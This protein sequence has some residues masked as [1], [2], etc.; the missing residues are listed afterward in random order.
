[1]GLSKTDWLDLEKATRRYEIWSVTSETVELDET[2]GGQK[3]KVTKQALRSIGCAGLRVRLSEV[4]KRLEGHVWPE[5]GLISL[6]VFA[7]TL[8]LDQ[9][10]EINADGLVVVARTIEVMELQGKPLIVR[11]SSAG[12]ARVMEVLAGR[13]VGGELKLQFERKEAGQVTPLG[14]YVVV[15]AADAYSVNFASLV[16]NAEGKETLKTGSDSD[17]NTLADLAETPFALG[18]FHAGIEAAKQLAKSEEQKKVQLAA[19]MLRW[20]EGCARASY[21]GEEKN[22]VVVSE[23]AD[24]A[25]ALLVSLRTAGGACFV[26]VLSPDV[27]REQVEQY[28]HA[29]ELYESDVLS[30]ETTESVGQVLEKVSRGL[31]HSAETEILPLKTELGMVIENLKVLEES[32]GSLS[33]DYL[34]QSKLCDASYRALEKAA[35]NAKQWKLIEAGIKL[36]FEGVSLAINMARYKKSLV[37]QL[38]PQLSKMPQKA[39]N[40]IDGWQTKDEVIKSIRG[41]KLFDSLKSTVLSSFSFGAAFADAV[42]GLGV[43]NKLIR[44]AE[45]LLLSQQALVSNMERAARAWAG[46]LW[47]DLDVPTLPEELNQFRIEPNLAWDAYMLQAKTELEALPTQREARAYLNALAMLAEYG[48]AMNAKCVIYCEQLARGTVL[49]AQIAAA[50]RAAA[51]WQAL[52]EKSAT[53]TERRAVLRS[54]LELRAES[55]RQSIYVAWT[56]YRSCHLYLLFERPPFVVDMAMT[57]AELRDEWNGVSR[58]MTRLL[59]DDGSKHAVTLP[60]SQVRIDFELPVIMPDADGTEGQV[61]CF[62]PATEERGAELRWTIPHGNRQWAGILPEDG[63]VAVWVESARLVLEGVQPNAAGN[64]IV[65]LGTSGCYQNGFGGDSNGSF[66]NKPMGAYYCFRPR[67]GGDEIYAPWTMNAKRYQLPTPFTQWSATFDRNG[68]DASKV[69]KLRLELTVAFRTRA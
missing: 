52:A 18:A 44:T 22:S 50:T 59:G 65:R 11:T 39:W 17:A 58:W 36:T 29:L 13:I 68:G 37:T 24:Q 25:S 9:A 12:R 21:L 54:M 10:L 31:G 8:V 27:Y 51:A 63:K 41:S 64:V 6:T 48:R 28:L 56:Y 1:M 42:S 35:R 30:L 5:E 26:P 49:K 66:V 60:A 19:E 61:A 23:M 46:S 47:S 45:T 62:A 3:V 32:I 43:D 69:T 55:I 14:N 2:R 7:D 4:M 67:Q 15:A 16:R 57:A 38:A 20:V 40:V 33:S 53:D 34:A